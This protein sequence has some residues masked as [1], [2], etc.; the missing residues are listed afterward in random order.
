MWNISSTL[1]RAVG[2]RL[3]SNVQE[4]LSGKIEMQL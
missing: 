2:D 1:K 4:T 3:L